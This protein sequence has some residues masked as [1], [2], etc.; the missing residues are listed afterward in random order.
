VAAVKRA[1]TDSDHMMTMNHLP[2]LNL[3]HQLAV[4]WVEDDTTSHTSAY[5]VEKLFGDEYQEED[6]PGFSSVRHFPSARRTRGHFSS[7][8]PTTRQQGKAVYFKLVKRTCNNHTTLYMLYEIRTRYSQYSSEH[9]LQ[10]EKICH[11]RARWVCINITV[12]TF[13]YVF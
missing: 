9:H 2:V 5:G 12:V 10:D 1:K 3:I 4:A 11:A 13:E 6:D 7:A 8:N